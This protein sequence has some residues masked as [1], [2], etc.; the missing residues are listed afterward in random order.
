[1]FNGKIHYKSPFSIAMLVYQRVDHV[2]PLWSRVD[3]SQA[4]TPGLC[5]DRED[6]F[7]ENLFQVGEMPT[8]MG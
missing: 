6:I 3:S 7:L 5:L 1:M 8:D 2:Q 4:Q